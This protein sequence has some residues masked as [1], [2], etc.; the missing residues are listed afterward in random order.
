MPSTVIRRFAYRPEAR[1]LEIL[2]VTGRRYLYSDFPEGE[3]QRFRAA[4]LKGS[5]STNIFATDI[6]V[7]NWIPFRKRTWSAPASQ[8]RHHPVTWRSLIGIKSSAMTIAVIILVTA[9]A[10]SWSAV[11]LARSRAPSAGKS[12]RSRLLPAS[13]I[14]LHGSPDWPSTSSVSSRCS[15]GQGP[16]RSGFCRSTARPA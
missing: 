15:D 2:F 5:I 16:H 6:P 12:N 8:N 11:R 14:C 1:E 9:A 10:L 3:A 13:T 4:F 7:V